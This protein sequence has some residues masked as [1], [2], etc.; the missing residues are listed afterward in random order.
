MFLTGTFVEGDTKVS[1]LAT[2]G[3]KLPVG[4]KDLEKKTRFM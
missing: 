4:L 3:L 1:E 2:K